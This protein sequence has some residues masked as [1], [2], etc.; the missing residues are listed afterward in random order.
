MGRAPEPPLPIMDNSNYQIYWEL[1]VNFFPSIFSYIW[2]EYRD[3]LAT[4]TKTKIKNFFFNRFRYSM[5]MTIFI[6]H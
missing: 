5:Y 3:L 6:S 1:K 4:T 2:I